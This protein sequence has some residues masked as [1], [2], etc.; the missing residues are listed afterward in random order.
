MGLR[1][2][3]ALLVGS[4]IIIPA[5]TAKQVAGDLNSMLIVATVVALM[6]ILGGSALASHFHGETGPVIV[7]VAGA[8]FVLTLFYRRR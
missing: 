6:A 4:L 2:L 7:T 1:Y 8:I 5:A 3:G